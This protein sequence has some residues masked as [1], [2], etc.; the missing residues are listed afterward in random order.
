MKELIITLIVLFSTTALTEYE[1]K[2]L[3]HEYL[4]EMDAKP[5][6]EGKGKDQTFFVATKC[7][8]GL[9]AAF[10]GDNPE[11]EDELGD[12]LL[13]VSK[14]MGYLIDAEHKGGKKTKGQVDTEVENL[15]QS[16]FTEY[17]NHQGHW[18]EN[19][20][21]DPDEIYSPRMKE[22]LKFC[23]DFG[24]QMGIFELPED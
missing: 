9:Y 1:I 20:R 11:K 24:E 15:I 5:D 19:V 22:D 13:A 17:V 23:L 14:G 3:I 10:G 6:Y 4:D 21:T 7:T 12:Q 2:Q 16:Y 18:Y 8:A